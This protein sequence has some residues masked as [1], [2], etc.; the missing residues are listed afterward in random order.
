[1]TE[2]VQDRKQIKAAAQAAFFVAGVVLIT[3][4]VA[5]VYLPAGVIACGVMAAAAGAYIAGGE[6]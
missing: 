6:K 4:G 1:M 5:L 3:V 2:P